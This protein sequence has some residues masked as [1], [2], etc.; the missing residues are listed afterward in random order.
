MSFLRP[1]EYLATKSTIQPTEITM[2]IAAALSLL[3]ML[4][5]TVNAQESEPPLELSVEQ[6]DSAQVIDE[7]Q[8]TDIDQDSLTEKIEPEDRPPKTF[9]LLVGTSTFR[10]I[11]SLQRPTAKA[12]CFQNALSLYNSESIAQADV[13]ALCEPNDAIRAQILASAKQLQERTQEGDTILFIF[14][15]LGVGGD[16]GEPMFLTHDF[17]PSGDKIES[18]SIRV[19]ELTAS[20]AKEG[21]Q[22]I[23]LLDASMNQSLTLSSGD[24]LVTAGPIA[25]DISGRHLSISHTARAG[26]WPQNENAFGQILA[27]G[28]QGD[29]DLDADGR[30]TASELNRFL[31]QEVVAQSGM[32]PGVRGAWVDNASTIVTLP[33]QIAE[34]IPEVKRDWRPSSSLKFKRV[35]IIGGSSLLATSAITYSL[36]WRAHNRVENTNY[37]DRDQYDAL[38]LQRSALLWTSRGAGALGAVALGGGII[39]T[40]KS[41]TVSVTARW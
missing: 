31:V 8:D 37:S 6:I 20:L 17:T 24:S 22:L 1:F 13:V 11:E 12:L 34:P 9:A 7:P 32:P 5:S 41:A 38:A 2:I 23:M 26:E 3:L 27:D 35:A 29:A 33:V 36:A 19:D 15:G 30:I 28:L 10:N 39:V 14:I 25:A 18:T 16:F 21:V 4:S 40:P